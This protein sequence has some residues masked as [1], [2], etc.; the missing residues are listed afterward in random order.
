MVEVGV[1]VMSLFTDDA[2]EFSS[3]CDSLTRLR[4]PPLLPLLLFC[5]GCFSSSDD[6]RFLFAK[7]ELLK[8]L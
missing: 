7:I 6:R 5:D 4:F 3:F 2:F 1:V 8:L